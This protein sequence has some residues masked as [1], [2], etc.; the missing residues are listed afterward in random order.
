MYLFFLVVKSKY[1][2]CCFRLCIDGS[3]VIMSW[4]RVLDPGVVRNQI[5][6]L[7]LL[8]FGLVKCCLTQNTQVQQIS[9]FILNI[10]G[11]TNTF[12]IHALV[13]ESEVVVIQIKPLLPLHWFNDIHQYDKFNL[14]VRVVTWTVHMPWMFVLTEQSW[15]MSSAHTAWLFVFF[16][17]SCWHRWHESSWR[18]PS[19]WFGCAVQM[20]FK[21]WLLAINS[22][23][24]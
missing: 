23:C 22:D 16:F 18:C 19:S 8:F 21:S 13:R 17:K 3:W 10:K 12:V 7:L 24:H 4:C 6:K 5:D 20:E 9:A 11:I 15:F 14:S 2:L 1:F